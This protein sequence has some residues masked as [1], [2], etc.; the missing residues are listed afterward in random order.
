MDAY[1]Q[2]GRIEATGLGANA[3]V[4]KIELVLSR[5]AA[6]ACPHGGRP[7][8]IRK[9]REEARC[10]RIQQRLQQERFNVVRPVANGLEQTASRRVIDAT[11]KK[12]KVKL[13]RSSTPL[14]VT[15]ATTISELKA[16]V[17]VVYSIPPECRS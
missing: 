17:R 11:L 16:A 15:V 6:V 4:T 7:S 2:R 13:G 14:P 8:K 3:K 12:V 1:L 5:V 9:T 10:I